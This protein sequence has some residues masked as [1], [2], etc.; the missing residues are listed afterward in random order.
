M[1]LINFVTIEIIWYYKMILQGLQGARILHTLGPRQSMFA[2]RQIQSLQHYPTSLVMRSCTEPSTIR[3]R[4][5]MITGTIC[6]APCAA[7]GPPPAL[8]WYLEPT[9]VSLVGELSIR[10][11][12]RRVPMTKQRPRS[13]YVWT[14][15]RKLL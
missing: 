2:F 11:T 1:Y 5:V 3:T 4:S 9:I 13:I 10:V 6:H 7:V 14:R 15:H 8:S 12:L